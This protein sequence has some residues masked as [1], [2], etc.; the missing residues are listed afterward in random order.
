[1]VVAIDDPFGFAGQLAE[2]AMGL[3]DAF[4]LQATASQLHQVR[5]RVRAALEYRGPALLAIFTGALRP[6]LPPYLV[7]AAALEARVVPSFTCD[8]SA[9]PNFAQRFALHDNPQPE[10]PWPVHELSWADEALQRVSTE[11]A[12][13]SADYAI[14]DPRQAGHFAR[15][16]R[17]RWNGSLVRFDRWQADGAAGAVPFVYALDADA[18]V[19]RLVVDER[20]ART[21]RRHAEAWHRLRELD[22]LKRPPAIAFVAT[23][24]VTPAEVAAV[25]TA[26]PTPAPEP[27]A[28]ASP[29]EQLAAAAQPAPSRD[30]AY[31]ETAR[32]TTCNECTGVNARVFAYN[33][34]GQATIADPAAGTYRDLVDAAERCQVA[35]IHPGKP[36]NPA[37]LGLADLLERA[38][39]FR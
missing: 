27:A 16:P 1:M 5:D 36:R 13:T 14:C 23:V 38:E 37:E 17:E 2:S 31:I 7:A 8:P 34:N 24:E 39:P 22:A 11:C 28:S 6:D 3:G 20:L 35:I 30:D 25:E 29:S 4:V 33:A 18:G 12:F 21:A 15:V 26:A 32:C 9:G 19:H 10:R